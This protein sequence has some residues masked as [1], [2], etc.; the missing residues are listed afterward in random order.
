MLNIDSNNFE[1]NSFTLEYIYILQQSEEF[2]SLLHITV[3][4]FGYW[5]LGNLWK[6]TSTS[7][8][9]IIRN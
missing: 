2:S 6:P 1:M 5:P 3:L 8:Q 7:V 4:F 9:S